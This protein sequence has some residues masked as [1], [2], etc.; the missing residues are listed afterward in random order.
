MVINVYGLFCF[1]FLESINMVIYSNVLRRRFV[2][3]VDYFV[4]MVALD[5]KVFVYVHQCSLAHRV[6]LEFV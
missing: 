3:K 6:N 2:R 1:S 5:I 4:K